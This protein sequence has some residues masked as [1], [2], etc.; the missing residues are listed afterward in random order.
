MACHLQPQWKL[1]CFALRE[2]PRV[3]ETED[4]CTFRFQ[5]LI[6]NRQQMFII[7]FVNRGHMRN[8]YMGTFIPQPNA[9]P[10]KVIGPLCKLED[11]HTMK[12]LPKLCLWTIYLYRFFKNSDFGNLEGPPNWWEMGIL[13]TEKPGVLYHHNKLQQSLMLHSK[14]AAVSSDWKSYIEV[15]SVFIFLILC[16]L[17]RGGLWDKLLDNEVI[18]VTRYSTFDGLPNSLCHMWQSLMRALGNLRPESVWTCLKCRT[19]TISGACMTHSCQIVSCFHVKFNTLKPSRI[20]IK[21][22]ELVA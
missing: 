5:F 17:V 21:D 9:V 15:L 11:G 2:P 8:I 13:L 4:E 1:H 22:A 10:N 7:N 16:P 18:L 20:P 14:S 6:W 12:Q 3:S 19:S